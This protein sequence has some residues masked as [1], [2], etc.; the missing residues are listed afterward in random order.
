[1]AVSMDLPITLP[2][3]LRPTVAD[4]TIVCIESKL[5]RYGTAG[6]VDDG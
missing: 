5:R 6:A 3:W 2:V 4:E 1:M